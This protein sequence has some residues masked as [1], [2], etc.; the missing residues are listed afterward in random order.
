ME[1]DERNGLPPRA[2]ARIAVNLASRKNPPVKV[3]GGR[4]YALFLF[5]NRIL[6]ARLVSYI[7]AKMYA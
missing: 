5:L 4:K 6:P 1:K 2:I 3:A 7:L